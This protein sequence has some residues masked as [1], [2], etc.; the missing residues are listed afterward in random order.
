MSAVSS[1]AG[2][3]P[4]QITAGLLGYPS[5]CVA[6][7]LR[8]HAHGEVEDLFEML[9]GMI[10]FHLP[11]GTGKPLEVL[12]D[13][14]RLSQDLGLDSLALTEMAFVLDDLFGVSF[15]TREMATVQTVGDLKRFLVRK[16]G[17]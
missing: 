1:L 6:A 8:F 9:P 4:D 5:P 10:E 2:R 14:M 16:L 7:A 13:E 15:E 11:S 12:K 17:A 3:T